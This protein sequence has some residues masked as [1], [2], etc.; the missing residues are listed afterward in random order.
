MTTEAQKKKA[1][2]KAK[3]KAGS[4]EPEK[5]DSKGPE[6]SE[7][8]TVDDLESQYPDL[9]SQIRDDVI[10][11][12]G[13]C[14]AKDIKLNM[15]ELYERIAADVPK[16]SGIDMREPGFLLDVGDPFAA[17]AMRTYAR[18]R[19]LTGL[20]LPFVLPFKTKGNG[21]IRAEAWKKKFE[22][23]EALKA[24]FKKVEAYVAFKS[25][26]VTQVL[27]HY[28]QIADGAGDRERVAAAR[29]AMTKIK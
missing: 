13:A 10:I 7:I 6:T 26:V 28:I 11:Q 16:H 4:K 3:A 15:P 5:G 14:P 1:A 17:G 27:E 24:Q 2:E 23:S 29:K 20:H 22:A 25:K 12:I 9:V 21:D 8:N 19:K 18:L